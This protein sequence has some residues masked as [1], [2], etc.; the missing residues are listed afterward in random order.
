MEIP[1]YLPF[2]GRKG[3]H[4]AEVNGR[5]V[6]VRCGK[7]LSA[8]ARWLEQSRTDDEFYPVGLL[9][10]GHASNGNFEFGLECAVQLVERRREKVNQP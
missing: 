7:P 8:D 5:S 1:K 2:N 10:V 6:C 9:P 3:P 4:F